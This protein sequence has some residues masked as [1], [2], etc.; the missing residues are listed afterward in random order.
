[1]PYKVVVRYDG[2]T[3]GM[4][5]YVFDSEF[6]TAKE[7]M[8]FPL[9]DE[10]AI[11]PIPAL[12]DMPTIQ[13]DVE[14]ETDSKIESV[15]PELGYSEIESVIPELE[16]YIPIIPIQPT[17][18]VKPVKVVD[19]GFGYVHWSE[20]EEWLGATLT[21]PDGSVWEWSENLCGWGLIKYVDE[22]GKVWTYKDIEAGQARWDSIDWVQFT[23]P[24]KRPSSANEGSCSSTTTMA[25]VEAKL[26]QLFD[27]IDV[28][29]SLSGE[30]DNG[31][32]FGAVIDL[33]ALGD[34]SSKSKSVFLGGD[35]GKISIPDT[36]LAFG[37]PTSLIESSFKP[38]TL[39]GPGDIGLNFYENQFFDVIVPA[40]NDLQYYIDDVPTDTFD[41][42]YNADLVIPERFTPYPVNELP[43]PCCPEST[44][45]IPRTILF[46]QTVVERLAENS[47]NEDEA[48]ITFRQNKPLMINDPNDYLSRADFVIL[49][50]GPGDLVLKY[51]LAF[52]KQGV[53]DVSL[54]VWTIDRYAAQETFPSPIIVHG[55]EQDIEF[56]VILDGQQGTRQSLG[57]AGILAGQQETTPIISMD[58]LNDWAGYS[59]NPI[60]DAEFLSH[61]GI[62]GDEIPSWYKQSPI[63]KWVQ[64]D[65]VPQNAVV[66]SLQFFDRQGLLGNLR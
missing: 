14:S 58:V 32:T 3:N 39:T 64:E 44:N 23:P 17:K 13:F 29:F 43:L 38:L 10:G 11:I 55:T 33:D 35:F 2:N 57:F 26:P 60:S 34:D 51:D 52:K 49:E 6:F 21:Y 50:K 8:N 7:W 37:Q 45:P 47:Y 54:D 27:E 42:N 1:M 9:L 63:T 41:S 4:E 15:I 36:E 28:S 30:A 25:E 18:G 20:D 19:H 24:P 40:L 66:N 31:L 22:D 46:G 5:M 48:K 56:N 61:V 16:G 59:N 62:K 53:F 65:R 12:T